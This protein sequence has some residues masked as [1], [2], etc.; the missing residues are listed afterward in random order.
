M[1]RTIGGKESWKNV[2][3]KLIQ[4]KVKFRWYLF[5]FIGIPAVMF[6]GIIILN[7]GTIPSFHNL[8]SSYFVSYPILFI[9]IFFFGGPLSEEIGWRG[10]ALPRMQLRYGAL[11]ASLFIG[12]LWALWHL[13]HFLTVAQKGGPGTGLSI[14]YI[15]LPIFILSCIAI[16]II[17]TW[18]FNRTQESLFIVILLHTSLNIFSTIQPYLSRP[19]LTKTDLPFLIG[20]A[21]LALLILIF[22]RGT[23][24]YIQNS[25]M[26]LVKDIQK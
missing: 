22:T 17:F 16:S 3:K 19:L 25:N 14:F 6:L 20:V 8:T 18:V 1:H 21:F 2:L 12:V 26:L 11:K 4:V 5:I 7:G 13:P 9:L 24:G 23:L 10:F 15:N